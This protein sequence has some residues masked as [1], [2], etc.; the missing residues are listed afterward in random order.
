MVKE[1]EAFSKTKQKGDPKNS[2]YGGKTTMHELTSILERRWS[3]P[4]V[5]LFLFMQ[6]PVFK[7]GQC[8]SSIVS[9]GSLIKTPGRYGSPRQLTV[10]RASP[11]PGHDGF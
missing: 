10:F 5:E 9:S 6:Y 11:E 3:L 1:I 4:N 2:N 8:L 7:T